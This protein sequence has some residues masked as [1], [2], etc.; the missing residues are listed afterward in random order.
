MGV[1]NDARM[2]N[3]LKGLTRDIEVVTQHKLKLAE[4]F[5]LKAQM[6]AMQFHFQEA[7]TNYRTACSLDPEN[8]EYITELGIALFHNGQF[9]ESRLQLKSALDLELKKEIMDS[10]QLGIRYVNYSRILTAMGEYDQ[11]LEHVS[12]AREELQKIDESSY[13]AVEVYMQLGKLNGIYVEWE[14]SLRHDVKALQI[15]IEIGVSGHL[16]ADL[17]NNVGVCYFEL[18]DYDNALDFLERSLDVERS[19]NKTDAEIGGHLFYNLGSVNESLGNVEEGL[20]LMKKAI[21]IDTPLLGAE[22]FQLAVYYQGLGVTLISIDK[23]AAFMYLQQAISIRETATSFDHVAL[24]DSYAAMAILLQ[25]DQPLQSIDYLIKAIHIRE[26]VFGLS[27]KIVGQLYSYLATSYAFSGDSVS[28][29]FYEE[30]AWLRIHKHPDLI[31]SLKTQTESC[32][33]KFNKQ[34]SEFPV[35][36][37][38]R[39]PFEED[40]FEGRYYYQSAE[41][42]DCDTSFTCFIRME[43]GSAFKGTCL[44][45]GEDQAGNKISRIYGTLSG[46][47]ITFSKVYL[48][49]C[50]LQSEVSPESPKKAV[51]FY[52][53][54]YVNDAVGFTGRWEIRGDSTDSSGQVINSG[55]WQMKVRYN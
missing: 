34:L 11:A 6:Q 10:E 33:Q 52:K 21:E 14:S 27:D 30:E 48:E 46:N 5:A 9:A 50:R 20:K 49:L 41:Q 26:N 16:V 3:E 31:T 37:I 1:L 17:F 39:F 47:I 23:E 2:Q 45:H 43:S 40:N 36:R 12:M 7:F 18:K 44:D 35:Q 24:A 38:L 53:G 25:T 32:I 42:S 15:A 51:V 4:T 22:H 19:L 29:L 54:T 13:L 55:F 28:A 8:T